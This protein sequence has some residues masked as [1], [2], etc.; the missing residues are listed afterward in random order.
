MAWTQVADLSG[1]EGPAGDD[2]VS[3]TDATIDAN[4]DLILTLSNSGQINAGR[5]K[6]E[7]GGGIDFETSVATVGDLPDYSADPEPHYGEARYVQADGHLYVW[8]EDGGGVG[9]PGWTDVGPIRGETGPAGADG[10]DGVSVTGATVNASGDLVISL[11]S[12]APITAGHVVGPEGEQGATGATG[13]R[14]A[15]WFTGSGAPAAQPGELPGDLYLD[16][17]TGVVYLLS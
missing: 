3:V 4:G 8:E 13:P 15:T 7:P 14:G 2:G 6:G 5:A 12:G 10:T 16:T 11:S 9:V 17:A 1:P